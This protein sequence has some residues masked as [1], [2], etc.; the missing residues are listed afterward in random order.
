MCVIVGN[1][2]IIVIDRETGIYILPITALLFTA[3]NLI[4]VK[5]RQ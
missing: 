4:Y 2:D 1:T 3:E 5:S